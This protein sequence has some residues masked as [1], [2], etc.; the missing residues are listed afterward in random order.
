M[1]QALEHII[2]GDE[3]QAMYFSHRQATEAHLTL[4]GLNIPFINH[5]NYLGVIFDKRIT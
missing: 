2:N 3:T 4:N 5:V 1:V